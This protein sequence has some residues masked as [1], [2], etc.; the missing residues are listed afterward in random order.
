LFALNLKLNI[1][2]I[3]GLL[4]IAGLSIVFFKIIIY[5]I[6]SMVLF[7]LGYPI[8]YRLEKI[9]IGKRKLPDALA[10]LITVAI[11]VG[12]VSGLFMIIIPP[13]VTEVQFLSNLN[14]YDV[15]HN[16]LAQFPKFKAL[17]LKLGSEEDLKQNL[18][19]HTQQLV[20]TN[21]ITGAVNHL[22][23]YFGIVSGGALIVLF[24]TFFLLKDE[25]IVKQSLLTLT[26]SGK[27][28]E[29]NDI[30]T[31]SKKMLSKYFAALFTD[32]L[33][34]GILTMIILSFLGIKNALLISFVAGVL[35]VIPYIGSVITMIIAIFLGVSGCINSGSYELI[36]PTINKIFFALLS[37]N[38]FDGFILQP[39]I[40]SSSVKAHPLEIFIVTL[41]AATIGGIP[42][43]IVAL[44]VYTLLRIVAREFLTHLKFFKK[45]SENIDE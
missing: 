23:D 1:W 36:G 29:M 14:F 24:I 10:A 15:L 4:L 35:N 20:N 21:N 39:V 3:L 38:L 18:V 42:G 16:I 8:T 43:M 13:L 44:P 37:V 31:T 41:M 22:F 28:S 5:L 45:I 30:L 6:I 7:L 19:M 25:Q 34:V 26:P 32:M 17:L 27:E 12:L 2:R 33:I 40:F 9:R 11:L